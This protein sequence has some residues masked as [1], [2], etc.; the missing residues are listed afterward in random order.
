ML[1]IRSR[2]D[3]GDVVLRR[4][5]LPVVVGGVATVQVRVVVVVVDTW[6]RS[7]IGEDIKH[8]T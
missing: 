2:R 1:R 8:K 7:D 4:S 3:N 6:V 5:M